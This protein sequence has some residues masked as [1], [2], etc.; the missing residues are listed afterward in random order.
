MSEMQAITQAYK[1]NELTTARRRIREATT[2]AQLENV[3]DQADMYYQQGLMTR[4]QAESIAYA[5]WAKSR[6]MM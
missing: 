1:G 5:S 3:C 4:A 2:L 6:D